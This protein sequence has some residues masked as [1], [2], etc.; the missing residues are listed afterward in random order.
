MKSPPARSWN[1]PR[2][3]NVFDN[4]LFTFY[5][6]FDFVVKIDGGYKGYN[7]L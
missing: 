2:M 4:R 1:L 5:F 3:G 6:R 7:L